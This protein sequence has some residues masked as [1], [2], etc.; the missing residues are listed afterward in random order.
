MGKIEASIKSEIVRLAKRE[1]RKTVAPLGRNVRLLRG[2]VSQLRQSISM[3]ER[4]AS[5]QEGEKAGEK[6]KLQA[7]PEEV[8]MSRFSPRLIRGLRERL[9]ITQ[10]EMATLADVTVGAVYQ[11]EKGI[12]EPRDEKKAA[13][14]AIRK[15]G[16]RDAKQILEEKGARAVAKKSP[17]PK[18]RPRA[19][20]KARA[21]ARGRRKPSRK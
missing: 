9:G 7:S 20:A 11:W 17:A 5:R 18:A 10:K 19:K 13:L 2:S 14:V 21:K 12:F 15:L 6:V 3:L 16:R 4:F 1:L 8:K